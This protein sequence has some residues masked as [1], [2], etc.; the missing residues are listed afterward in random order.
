MMADTPRAMKKDASLLRGSATKY[1][2]R[3]RAIMGR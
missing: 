1:R 3:N 2:I